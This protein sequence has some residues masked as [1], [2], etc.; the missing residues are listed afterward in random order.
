MATGDEKIK[1][2]NDR[3][4]LQVYPEHDFLPNL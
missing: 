3:M 2:D 1:N 4:K